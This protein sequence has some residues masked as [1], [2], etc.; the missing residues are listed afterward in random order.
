M[1]VCVCVCV[2]M[3]VCIYLYMVSVRQRKKENTKKRILRD[4]E[5]EKTITNRSRFFLRKTSGLQNLTKLGNLFLGSR[6]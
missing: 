5:I 3:Y 4:F 2:C 1:C 6:V